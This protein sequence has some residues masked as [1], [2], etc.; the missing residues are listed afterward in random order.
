M[1]SAKANEVSFTDLILE[2]AAERSE[3][4]PGQEMV[5]AVYLYIDNGTFASSLYLDDHG[6]VDMS[7]RY[8]QV[9]LEH[10][11]N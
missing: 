4:I 9:F 3:F 8:V 5:A 11:K 7:M 10:P 2:G 1:I 6:E